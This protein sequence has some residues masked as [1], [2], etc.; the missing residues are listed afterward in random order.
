MVCSSLCKLFN[1]FF[2]YF[3]IFLIL[4]FS[5]Y[6]IDL[7]W[8]VV[9]TWIGCSHITSI[10][11]LNR[12]QRGFLCDNWIRGKINGENCHN[13]RA[14]FA[15]PLWNVVDRIQ[16]GKLNN[17][18]YL[19]FKTNLVEG[20]VTKLV[21]KTVLIFNVWGM[22]RSN[23]SMEAWHRVWNH[24]FAAKPKLSRFVRKMMKENYPRLGIIR[25]KRYPRLG[26]IQFRTNTF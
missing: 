14:L 16:H 15:I 19:L 23:N 24:M 20:K 21:L 7:A 11:P 9:N 12:N 22:V 4:S 25:G 2:A 8:Y 1:Y 18:C 26:Q 13:R 5:F 6:L 17:L 10:A 3:L